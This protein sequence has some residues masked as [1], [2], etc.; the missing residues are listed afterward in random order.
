MWGRRRAE[1]MQWT[2]VSRLPTDAIRYVQC[3]AGQAPR[4]ALLCCAVRGWTGTQSGA[5][6]LCSAWLDRR[7]ERRCCAVQFLRCCP[8]LTLH[9]VLSNAWQCHDAQSE[10][11]GRLVAHRERHNTALMCG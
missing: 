2:V 5:A 8:L 11:D 7:P 9:T 10:A 3:V 6:V 4:A 1:V